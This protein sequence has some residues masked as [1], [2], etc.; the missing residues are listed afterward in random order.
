M[1][2]RK[3]HRVLIVDDHPFVRDGL[4][5]RLATEPDLE[6]CGEA[7]D[8]ADALRCFDKTRPDAVIV[9]IALKSGNGIDLIERIVAREPSAKVLVL[10]MYADTLYAERALRAG[11]LG[12]LNKQEVREK[13]IDALRQILEGRCY[14]SSEMHD[15]LVHLMVGGHRQQEQAPVET[16]SN[17]ELEVYRLI[18]EGVKTSEIAARLHISTKTVETHR[19]RIKTKLGLDSAAE[20]T[21]AA[22]QWMLE[23]G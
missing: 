14:L 10:S 12:Y 18:G 1:T 3:T 21:R 9:D 8:V 5:A 13:V 2:L 17:R 6:V 11:A 19:Q 22:T 23:N 20:L 4:A 16:L 7:E 15:R